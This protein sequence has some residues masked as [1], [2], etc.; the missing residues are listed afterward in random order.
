MDHLVVFWMILIFNITFSNIIILLFNVTL[1]FI[2]Y[3]GPLTR[4]NL[5]ITIYIVIYFI[6]KF[7]YSFYIEIGYR[8]CYDDS[9]VE[10]TIACGMLSG[11]Y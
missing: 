5:S 2:L 9:F 3:H 6:L 10:V 7:L 8:E 11:T 4:R 1:L